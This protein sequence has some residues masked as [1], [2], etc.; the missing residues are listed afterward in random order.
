MNDR[1]SRDMA[2]RI[3]LSVVRWH[4]YRDAIFGDLAEQRANIE[5]ESGAVAA[6]RWYRA[7]VLRSALS[8]VRSAAMSP[9]LAARLAT[10]VAVVYAVAVRVTNLAALPLAQFLGTSRGLAFDAMYLAVIAV[11]AG[12]A[13]LIV[14]ASA[15]RFAFLSAILMVALA[16]AVGI[17]HVLGASPGEFWF[18]VGKV[19]V[20]ALGVMVG[21]TSDRRIHAWFVTH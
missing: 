14:A 16:I 20:F 19:S 9:S 4:P 7:E 5:A 8:I 6:R 2:S 12:G 21:F 10:V 13:G 3:L 11:A 18:R 1:D 17:V 15:R